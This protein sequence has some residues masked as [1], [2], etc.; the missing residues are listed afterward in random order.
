[1]AATAKDTLRSR[2]AETIFMNEPRGKSL[3]G[4]LVARDGRVKQPK[5]YEVR[6]IIL[7]DEFVLFSAWVASLRFAQGSRDG[8]PHMDW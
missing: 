1:M 8:C 5:M 6:P 4:I 2:R 3:V 7:T